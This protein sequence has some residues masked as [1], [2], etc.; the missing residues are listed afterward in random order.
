MN[1]GLSLA[2]TLI[3]M[4]SPLAQIISPSLI[5]TG[6]PRVFTL[7]SL[8]LAL[9]CLA[10]VIRLPL[11]PQLR[12]KVISL[13]DV[14]SYLLTAVGFGGLTIP[15]IVGTGYWWF[16]ADWLGVLLVGSVAAV[17][18]TA[19]I[20]LNRK[21]PLLDIR[22]LTSPAVVHLTG[23]LLVFRVVLSEQTS[24]A[25]G[26][27]QQLGLGAAQIQMMYV[28][29]VLASI[30]GGAVCM[31]MLKPGREG[32]LH[33]VALALIAV[34]AWVDSQATVLTRPEQM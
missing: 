7:L 10:L 34:G 4:G 28:V 9:L 26:L 23:A 16:E 1:V 12:A 27:F 17:T 22:W 13:L 2:L 8:G 31:V 21:E 14:V 19:L 11:A 18:V 30:A 20:E 15:F 33:L 29:I 32:R 6:L 24:G 3:M 25:P 5:D